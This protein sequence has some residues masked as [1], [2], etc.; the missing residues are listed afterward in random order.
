MG[1]R[2]RLLGR[3]R[4]VSGVAFWGCAGTGEGDEGG[5]WLL[6]D[7]RGYRWFLERFV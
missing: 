2:R 7:Q 1:M 5:A 6:R 4:D 3:F